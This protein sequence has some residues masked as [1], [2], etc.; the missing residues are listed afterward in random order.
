MAL[1][2]KDGIITVS[3]F[4]L[5]F[6]IPLLFSRWYIGLTLILVGFLNAFS[7]VTKDITEQE[8]HEIRFQSMTAAEIGE[9]LV[10]MDNVRSGNE[11]RSLCLAALFVL[12]K[13]CNAQKQS[14][15]Y[16]PHE[17]ECICQEAA[18]VVLR[19][20]P[21]DDDA[22][23]A[24]L[25]LNALVASDSQVRERLVHEADIFG[26]NVIIGAM[27][28]SLKR[29]QD[30]MEP[31]EE[32]EQLSAELQ[33]KACLLLGALGDNDLVLATK[34]VDEHG[35][36]AILDAVKWYRY[37]EEVANWG[38]WAIFV[39]CYDHPGNKTELLRLGGIHV[40]CQTVKKNC[41]SLEVSRHG[42]AILFDMLREATQTPA[43]VVQIRKI[44]LSAGLHEVILSAMNE[45]DM[46]AEINMM[47]R[48]ILTGTGYS[49]E[50]P[51]FQPFS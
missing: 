41:H 47:G 29:T 26:V 17:L 12:A 38:L 4:L 46:S 39:L 18:Y 37:H 33:R 44:A 16:H 51:D 32:E 50:I 21:Q 5:L 30:S 42:I 34:I 36:E 25:S 1:F 48:E 49:G 14:S 24:A 19:L 27:R 9:E 6:G 10:A 7:Q 45:F 23:A 40:I 31:S 2:V 22:I 3:G 20:Y 28:S 35:L 43:H 15:H 13:K 11:Q 8:E